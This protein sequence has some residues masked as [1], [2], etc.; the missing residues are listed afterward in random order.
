MVIP[1]EGKELWLY[2]C[3]GTDGSDLEDF[4]V[5]LFKNDYL[6]DDDSTAADFTVATFTGYAQQPIDRS[7][8]GAVAI[9]AHVAEIYSTPF[10]TFTQT[11]GGVQLIYGW[12]MRGATSGVVLATQRFD[13]P[14][15]MGTGSTIDVDPFKFKLKT[16]T[17]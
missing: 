16:F 4:V 13:V 10:P 11:A 3:L 5:D 2:W 6:P 15:Q 14:R 9:V 12:Y 7:D 1:D 8:F 17:G